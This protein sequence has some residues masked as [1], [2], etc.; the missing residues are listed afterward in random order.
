MYESSKHIHGVALD[1]AEK[2]LAQSKELGASE[3][4]K[5]MQKS[6]DFNNGTIKIIEKAIIIFKI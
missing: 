3:F 2:G 4:I 1:A 5:Y 6:V